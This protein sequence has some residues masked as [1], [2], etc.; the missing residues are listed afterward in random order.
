MK[1]GEKL[2]HWIKTSSSL[3]GLESKPYKTRAEAG[4]KLTLL[5]NAND[6]PNIFLLQNFE[7]C[8]PPVSTGFLISFLFGFEDGGNMFH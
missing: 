2:T 3:S 4:V 5:F 6:G 8:L 7:L 1:F